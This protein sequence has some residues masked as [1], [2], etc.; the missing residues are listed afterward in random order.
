MAGLGRAAFLISPSARQIFNRA[1]RIGNDC[2]EIPSQDRFHGSVIPGDFSLPGL[3]RLGFR[4]PRLPLLGH[5]Q[6]PFGKSCGATVNFIPQTAGK[7]IN[8][9]HGYCYDLRPFPPPSE[10]HRERPRSD[11]IC[12]WA[13]SGCDPPSRPATSRSH[14]ISTSLAASS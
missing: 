2:P 8:L 9:V 3:S 14:S 1:S 10:F 7:E 6:T 5:F 4:V 11:L 13:Q 12:W